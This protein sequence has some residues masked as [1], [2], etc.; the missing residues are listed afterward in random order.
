MFWFF[1]GQCSPSNCPHWR[2]QRYE[3]LVFQRIVGE[4]AAYRDGAHEASGARAGRRAHQELPPGRNQ[5]RHARWV[6]ASRF[7][8]SNVSEW[9]HRDIKLAAL[10]T[11]NECKA[12]TEAFLVWTAS[13]NLR[14]DSQLVRT[15]P[16]RSKLHIWQT[17]TSGP[18]DKCN[19]T[20]SV[21]APLVLMR[22]S[23][24]KSAILP[25][26]SILGVLF[27]TLQKLWLGTDLLSITYLE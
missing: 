14:V 12:S 6:I 20:R 8:T 15:M 18:T 13:K 2:Q 10:G 1:A 22:A 17:Y 9:W 19:T 26:R 24:V 3:W 27:C 5:W 4:H 25:I 21:E 7:M 16:W 11:G 23:M